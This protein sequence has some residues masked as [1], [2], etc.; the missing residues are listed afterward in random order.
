MSGMPPLRDVQDEKGQ[1]VIENEIKYTED[2]RAYYE[3][4]GIDE[5]GNETV[6]KLMIEE[7]RD[8]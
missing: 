6:F 5:N 1:L 2:G 4:P 8:D 7:R 3:V